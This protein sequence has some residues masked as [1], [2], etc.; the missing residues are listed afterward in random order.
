MA[1][2]SAQC[3]LHPV[4]RDIYTLPEYQTGRRIPGGKRI[5][6]RLK[7]NWQFSSI[8]PNDLDTS[9]FMAGE[10]IIRWKSAPD[11]RPVG[12]VLSID[13]HGNM[14]VVI[15][16]DGLE[17][18]TF[19]P[20]TVATVTEQQSNRRIKRGAADRGHRWLRNSGSS[21]CH[22]CDVYAPESSMAPSI[23]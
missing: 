5:R 8:D 6:T 12:R 10:R 3:V 13:E 15:H 19:E 14:E 7:L 9:Y 20:E 17:D 22:G 1:I 21:A 11:K 2:D 4:S 16:F 23:E 18:A